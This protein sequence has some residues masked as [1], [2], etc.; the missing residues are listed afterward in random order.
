MKRFFK[1]TEIVVVSLFALIIVIKLFIF[2]RDKHE[3]AHNL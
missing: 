2:L 1:L 3:G